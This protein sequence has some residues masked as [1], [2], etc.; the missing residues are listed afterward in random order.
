MNDERER[1]VVTL[2]GIEAE[3]RRLSRKAKKAGA[4]GN[5]KKVE[6]AARERGK[7]MLA[8]LPSGDYLWGD[9]GKIEDRLVASATPP[10]A[11]EAQR[12]KIA[13]AVADGF[14]E[15]QI[16]H[17]R[18][19]VETEEA[20]AD[21]A[22]FR[23]EKRALG[24][25]EERLAR[26]RADEIEAE[27]A[28]EGSDE[29]GPVD[30]DAL[31]DAGDVEP[32]R[33]SLGSSRE[34]GVPLLYAAAYNGM[35]GEP[36]KGKTHFANVNVADVLKS[37]GTVDWVDTDANGAPATFSRLRS[38]GVSDETIR[39]RFRLWLP[40]TGPEFRVAGA[41]IVERRPDLCVLDSVGASMG[42]FGLDQLADRDYTAFHAQ[43]VA[44]IV[45]VGV[46]VLGLD[47]TMKTRPGELYAG[48]SS[49]KKRVVDG[50]YYTI[51]MF[52]DEPF[53]PGAVG[54]ATIR[55]AKD[56]HGGIGY[57]EGEVVAVFVLDTRDAANGPWDWRFHPGRSK[58]ERDAD[59]LGEDVKAL[60]ALEEPPLSKDDVKKRMKWGSDRAQKALARF[61]S[62]QSTFPIDPEPTTTTDKE[63]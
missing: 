14:A 10:G 13:Q 26:A 28:S 3:A 29:F 32:P 31:L 30:F 27:I 46:A 19:I 47:H 18:I 39:D 35:F 54:K 9:Y 11:D 16:D 53:R 62:L 59:Q 49:A 4:K 7:L 25:V 1:E 20:L 40:A 55:L 48:G 58:E 45:A 50:A 34:D 43:H 63:K 44:P 57:G 8:K 2:R 60:A 15:G 41:A 22:A 33:P 21:V 42:L 52:A 12:Q 56:R 6:D 17:R 5:L 36:G 24:I 37:G 51:D 23:T 61:R 38:A